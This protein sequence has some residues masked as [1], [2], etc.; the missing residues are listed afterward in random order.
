MTRL[1]QT[2][3]GRLNTGLSWLT[4]RYVALRWRLGGSRR[5][6][7]PSGLDLPVVVSLTSYPPR[8]PELLPT[9]TSLLMQTIRPD[10]LELWIA[11]GDFA[12]L[13]ADVLALRD[14]GLLIKVC[15]D[16]RSYKKIIPALGAHPDAL[17]VTADDDAY[18]WPT[19]LEE[20]VEAYDP[21]VREVLCHRAH[22]MVVREG[23]WPAPYSDWVFDIADTAPSAPSSRPASAASCISPASSCPRSSGR[24]CSRNTVRP[25]TISGSIGWLC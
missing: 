25:T 9:L 1:L 19:W 4:A 20:L 18:Y 22:K 5:P 2:L 11:D 16:L 8:Y 6:G 12:R 13:P 10:F 17:I 23:R 14:H 15:P 24:S 3:K 21:A 7:R